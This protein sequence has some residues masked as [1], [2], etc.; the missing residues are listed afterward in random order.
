M[1][2]QE[3]RLPAIAKDIRKGQGGIESLQLKINGHRVHYLKAGS[4][5]PVVLLHGGAS[6]CR[7][8][9]ETMATLAHRFTFYAPDLLGFGQSERDKK[10]YYLTDFSDFVVGFIDALQLVKPSLVGHSFGA[11]VCLDTALKR[12]EQVNRLILAD[13]SGLGKISG[14]GNALF[15]IFWALR[16]LLNRPQPF[17]KFLAKEGD[18]YNRVGEDALRKLT[19]PTLLVWKRHDLYLPVAIARRAEKLIPGARLVVLPGLGHAP[20]KQNRET[21]NRLLVEFLDGG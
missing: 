20:N 2:L 10:G 8:W 12:Q 21:F 19:I 17:P 5:P 6:D 9:V 14:L 1:F 11:R 18:D 16:K 13:A 15:T 4:G 3:S 7:D